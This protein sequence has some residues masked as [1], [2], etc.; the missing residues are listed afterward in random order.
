MSKHRIAIIG[1]GNS[2]NNHLH[3]IHAINDRV[4]LVAAV[5]INKER[6]ESFCAENN[7]PNSYTSV[8]EMLSTEKP[9][10]VSIITPSATH[11]DLTIECLDA[12]AW[13]FCEKPLCASLAEYDEIQAAEERTGN[14]VST[15]FQWRFGSAVK[16]LKQLIDEGSL[17]KPMIAVCNTLWYRTQAYYDVP[18]R[19]KFETAIGGPTITLG[20]HLMDLFLY[21]MSDWQSI[22]AVTDILDHDIE[23]E[24]ISMAMV[25]FESGARASIINSALSPR[26]ESYLRL[27]F[28][29]ATAEVKT[30]YR[31]S[32]EHWTFTPADSEDTVTQALW[33]A[34]DVD[35]SGSHHQELGEI[36]DA[37]ESNQRPPVSGDEARRI[38][39]FTASLYKSAFTGKPV[40]KG[41]ITP[42]DHFYYSNNGK[43]EALNQ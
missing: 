24:D 33:D 22:Y 32:N 37:M 5:D 14:F 18:W 30:L 38:I 2:V 9:D 28:Q 17:G 41:D 29:K 15:V 20:I 12:G 13:V 23:V 40:K 6:V 3:A 36:L 1:T 21:L 35:F 4:E 31:A 11:K 43:M 16:H 7:I 42:D 27:D 26:Q 34:L 25:Q 10:I 19:A 39:E 8:A